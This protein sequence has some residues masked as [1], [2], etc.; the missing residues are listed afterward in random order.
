MEEMELGGTADLGRI[1][2]FE[3]VSTVPRNSNKFSLNLLFSA[4]ISI[5]DF[6]Q[7]PSL[8]DSPCPTPPV[9]SY[10]DSR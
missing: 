5:A 4:C 10:I 3:E 7:P 8:S 1:G 2:V 6:S 9:V